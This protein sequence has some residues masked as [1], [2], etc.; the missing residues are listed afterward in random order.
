[1]EVCD[2][3]KGAIPPRTAWSR[4][5]IK[6][7]LLMLIAVTKSWLWDL[8]MQVLNLI[9]KYSQVDQALEGAIGS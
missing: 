6:E 8:I 9:Y 2:P 7:N 3:H 5:V 4:V 1:M